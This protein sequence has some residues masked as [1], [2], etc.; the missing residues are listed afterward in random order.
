MWGREHAKH[1]DNSE[2]LGTTKQKVILL[3][4]ELASGLG[5]AWAYLIHGLVYALVL[6]YCKYR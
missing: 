3:C 4:S 2:T 6:A 5:L 1:V